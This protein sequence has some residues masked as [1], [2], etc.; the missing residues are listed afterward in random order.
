MFIF[1]S[2]I[3]FKKNQLQ[4]L[5]TRMRTCWLFFVGKL[6]LIKVAKRPNGVHE[7]VR[8]VNCL[9]GHV[10]VS[11]YLSA[12]FS[13]ALAV[14]ERFLCC[15]EICFCNEPNLS[16]FKLWNNNLECVSVAVALMV[17]NKLWSFVDTFELSITFSAFLR[18]LNISKWGK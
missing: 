16:R 9:A 14:P 11:F 10:I 13:S 18:L 3:S 2:P 4:S 5:R 7:T 8:S 15:F 17:D 1:V 6:F 12:D